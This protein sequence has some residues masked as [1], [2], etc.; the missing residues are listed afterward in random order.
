M[1][2]GTMCHGYVILNRLLRS[3]ICDRDLSIFVMKSFLNYNAGL[4]YLSLQVAGDMVSGCL[5][6]IRDISLGI[7]GDECILK[8]I[9]LPFCMFSGGNRLLRKP[10]WKMLVSGSM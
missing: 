1:Q 6:I 8:G 2:S 4:C 7:E 3:F 10:V 9:L 5:M